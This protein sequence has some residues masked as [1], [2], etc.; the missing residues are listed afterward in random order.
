MDSN[1]LAPA[2]DGTTR[3]PKVVD[4]V[5]Y[6]P[7]VANCPAAS[8]TSGDMVAHA[9]PD[10]GTK[11]YLDAVDRQAE[12]TVNIVT[13]VVGVVGELGATVGGL[14]AI[15]DAAKT[16]PVVASVSD[17]A[18]GTTVG[19]GAQNIANGQ[20]LAGQ[21]TMQSSNSPF[22]AAGTLTQDAIDS[23]KVVPDLKPEL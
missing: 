2:A 10:A 5:A 13:T 16:T 8:C 3:V 6:Y 23:A 1:G 15:A 11:A 18:G 21:L 22:T 4:G 14:A 17:V 19:G 9:I 12:K 7:L 20:K